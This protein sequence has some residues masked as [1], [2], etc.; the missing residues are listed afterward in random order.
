MI[1][2]HLDPPPKSIQIASLQLLASKTKQLREQDQ[3]HNFAG[4]RKN[5]VVPA[6]DLLRMLNAAHRDVGDQPQQRI[7]QS[8]AFRDKRHW[9]DDA[10]QRAIESL[11]DTASEP[12]VEIRRQ[13]IR[14]VYLSRQKNDPIGIP[15]APLSLLLD[16]ID[17]WINLVENCLELQSQL[18]AVYTQFSREG[19]RGS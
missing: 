8:R 6:W 17:H 2:P 4:D 11:R 7:S 19:S 16:Q 3:E 15:G 12:Y 13:L 14:G 1:A 18:K 10:I 5:Q 9:I